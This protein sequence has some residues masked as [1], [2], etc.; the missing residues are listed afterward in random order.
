MH[1]PGAAI[2]DLWAF[3]PASRRWIDHTAS[4]ATLPSPPAA[5][6]FPGL[7]AMGGKLYLYGGYCS[8]SDCTNLLVFEPEMSSW[9]VMDLKEAADAPES[10][11]RF[12]HGF[13]AAGGRLYVLGGSTFDGR[14]NHDLMC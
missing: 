8:N 5:V 14:K 6:S 7:T 9:T 4:S 13:T 1:T 2:W 12:G 11:P 10:S 3:D